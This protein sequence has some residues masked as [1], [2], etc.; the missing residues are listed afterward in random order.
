[1]AKFEQ[2]GRENTRPFPEGNLRILP[3]PQKQ[4]LYS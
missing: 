1:M 4:K 2:I 3:L